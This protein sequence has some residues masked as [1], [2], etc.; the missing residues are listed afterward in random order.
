MRFERMQGALGLVAAHS[1]PDRH[2]FAEQR[3]RRK[4]GGATVRWGEDFL[5]Q[6]GECAPSEAEDGGGTQFPRALGAGGPPSGV[7]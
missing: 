7:I 6:G 5:P 3:W 4:V 1:S 2:C